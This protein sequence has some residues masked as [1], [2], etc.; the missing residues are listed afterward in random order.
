MRAD[1][2]VRECHG[3]LHLGN[4]V[5]LGNS[6]VL[7]DAIEFNADLRFIDVISD[8]A[9]TFMDL[10]DHGLE[11]HAWRFIGAYLEITGDY[12]GLKLLR[13][14]SVYRALVR[15][16]VALIR[17]HQPNLSHH[18][19][20]REHT[21]FEHYLR[22]AER[23]REPGCLV[24][25]AMS[26]LSGSGKSTAARTL[27]AALGGVRIRSDVERKR[28][29]G[30]T[31]AAE[32]A[33]RIYSVEANARTYDRLA[34]LAESVLRAE[35]PVVI[36]AAC[37]KRDERSRFEW[38]AAGLHAIFVLVV[39]EAP[40][41]VLRSRLQLRAATHDDASEATVDVL[42]RQVGWREPLDAA[43][44]QRATILDTSAGLD[45]VER[46]CLELAHALRARP[47]TVAA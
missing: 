39:C 12:D 7:F 5:L 33:G 16:K 24:L 41:D 20:L 3:D 2:F 9:F 23:L 35:V 45:E 15:A 21:S 18:G 34:L 37:L 29:H 28:L 4:I 40:V 14:Y 38:I 27:A 11:N 30:L 42:E 31:S 17:L 6:P 22:L 44:L 19:R 36:D 25:A 8:V 10:V 43:E 46:R 47:A 26:G 13:L 32:S 1:G